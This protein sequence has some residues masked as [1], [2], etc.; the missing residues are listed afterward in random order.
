MSCNVVVKQLAEQDTTAAYDYYESLSAGLGSRFLD[1]LDRLLS[2]IAE[3]PEMYQ[4]VLSGIRRALTRVFPYGVFLRYADGWPEGKTQRW[5]T[6]GELCQENEWSH[7]KLI[8]KNI[9]AKCDDI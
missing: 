9:I 5:S 7:D 1:E 8:H 2:L 3:H 6:D 4:E